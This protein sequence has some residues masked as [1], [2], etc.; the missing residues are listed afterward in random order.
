MSRGLIFFGNFIVDIDNVLV[1]QAGLTVK[2][3]EVS[4]PVFLCCSY[5]MLDEQKRTCSS[6]CFRGQPTA[7]NMSVQPYVSFNMLMILLRTLQCDMC[8][9]LIMCD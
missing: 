2:K 5:S 7:V 1:N 9:W 8:T 4:L 6:L 3:Q